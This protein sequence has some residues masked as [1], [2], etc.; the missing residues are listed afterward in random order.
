MHS[1]ADVVINASALLHSAHNGCKVVV[2]QDH[3]RCAL[4]YVRA[5]FSHCTADICGLQGGCVVHAVPCHGYDLARC[6]KCFDNAHLM[7]RGYAGKNTVI[8]NF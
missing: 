7:L 2:R 4:R 3:I 8:A 1:F 6:L 5:A